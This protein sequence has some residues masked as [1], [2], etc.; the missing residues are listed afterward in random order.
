[1]PR[2]TPLRWREI[3]DDLLRRIESG[4]LAEASGTAARRRL[5]AEKDLE[6]HYDASRNTIRD[7]LAWLANQ[8][9]VVSE[10][11]KG[12]FVVYR[13][14]TVHVTLSAVPLGLAPGSGEGEWYNR[15]AFIPAGQRVTVSPVKVEIQQGTQLIAWYLQAEP[16]ETFVSRH[17][18]IFVDERP[19]ALQTSF[20]PLRFATGGAPRLLEPTDIPQ[21]AV[22][23]LGETLGYEE[24]GFHDE[25]RARVPD[26]NEKRFFSLGDSAADVVFETNRTAYSAE[27]DA[28][29]LTVTVW[30]ADRT[31]LHYNDGK[32]PEQVMRA[33]GQTP[34]ETAKGKAPGGGARGG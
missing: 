19:W 3:A 2:A 31:R 5:P 8:G 24:V 15:D 17:Q 13:P 33:P 12:T 29:R 22:G 32:V 11:G 1:M 18:E 25:I 34:A 4:D 20:Y 14:S 10:Q 6:Q 26:G 9:R 16:G 28:F 27:G 7:A 30:P 23:Y 21:G